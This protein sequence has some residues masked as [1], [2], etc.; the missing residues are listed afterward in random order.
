MDPYVIDI[1][2]V[3][4]TLLVYGVILPFRPKKSARAYQ[5]VW[6]T[7]GSPL[8]SHSLKLVTQVQQSLGQDYCVKLGMRYGNPSI[9]SAL[10]QL[11]VEGVE[12]I[13]ALPLYPQ[14]SLA[15]T[16][17]SI[18][19]LQ[20]LIAKSSSVPAVKV[21]PPF[22]DHPAYLDAVAAISRP[23]LES[24]PWDHALFSFHGLPER[25]IRKTD[26]SKEHCFLTPSCC[27]EI[28]PGNSR[29]YR[30]QSFATAKALAERLGIA[31][32]KYT[33]CFQSRLGTTPWIR[34]YTDLLLAELPHKG[35]KKLAVFCPSFVADCLETL[36]EISIRGKEAFLNHGGESLFLVP[37]LNSDPLWA[38]AV[39]EM[40]T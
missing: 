24:H 17:S 3:G 10:N 21:L 12:E 7:E 22:Y 14:Y 28:A 18:A 19:K 30:A 34:P 16:E 13:I 15:A 38:K 26:P 39:S 36:E 35:I 29:C 1:G 2:R 33:V 11:L 5:K 6:T 8:L 23:H 9:E 27:D 25:Q 37:S 32:D 4:R 40:V 31:P 20:E